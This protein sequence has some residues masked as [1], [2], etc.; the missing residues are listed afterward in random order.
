METTTQKN[1]GRLENFPISFFAVVMGLAGLTISFKKVEHLWHWET[2]ISPVLFIISAVVYLIIAITYLTKLLRHSKQ[3]VEEF[4]H[5]IR[6]SFFPTISIGVLLLVIAGE[7]LLPRGVS[8]T[9]WTIGSSAQLIFTLIIMSAWIHHEKFQIHHSNASWFIPIVGNILVPVAGMS[10]GYVEVSWF[11]FSIGILFWIVL[12][13]I[14]MNRFFFHNPVPSKLLPTLFIL[15]APPAVGFIA[16]MRLHKGVLD[17][18]GRILYYAALFTTML[19]FFQWKQF[20]KVKFALPWW[21]YS[22]PTASITIASTLMLEKVGGTFF[23]VLVPAL[24]A[25]LSLMVLVLV[26]NTFRA[27]AKGEI[28]VPE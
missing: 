11:F 13:G 6:L 28:C 20:A 23:A 9:L 16:W 5:P 14:L 8:L 27:M 19:L 3:V 12:L 10:L 4:R 26:I 7:G 1:H 22:F 18:P 2:Q 24:L 25:L 21:A 17:D 15:I